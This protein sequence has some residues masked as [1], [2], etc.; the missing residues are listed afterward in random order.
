MHQPKNGAEKVLIENTGSGAV[1]GPER[2]VARHES[3]AQQDEKENE[4]EKAEE[5][6][7]EGEEEDGEEGPK[8]LRKRK[9]HHPG[10]QLPSRAR[11]YR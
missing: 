3:A 10:N 9:F 4:D 8:D 11:R 5:E 1:I 2:E 6:E 7:D